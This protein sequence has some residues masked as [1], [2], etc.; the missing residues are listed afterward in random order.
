[1]RVLVFSDIHSNF[2][3]LKAMLAK[4]KFDYSIFLGDAVDYGP[5]PGETLDLV[6]ENSDVRLMG[7]HDRAVA[8]DEDCRCA[9]EMHDLS[10]Y[11]RENISRKPGRG[12]PVTDFQAERRM[13][14]NSDG[15]EWGKNSRVSDICP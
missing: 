15:K 11:T 4:E 14:Q 9:L 2:E 10:E 1:M 8:Y 3:A 6:M 12:C 7:N 13:V 5:Q